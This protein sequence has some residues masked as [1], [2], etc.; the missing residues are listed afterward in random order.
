MNRK[1][2]LLALVIGLALVL[3]CTAAALADD[4]LKVQMDFSKKQFSGPETITVSITVT[5]V[6]EGD[7]PGPVTL[8]YPSGKRVEEFGSP[9]LTVGSSK[10]WQG[11]WT[12]TQ[13]E[14]EDGKITFQIRY[15]IYDEDQDDMV[16]KK[17]NFSKK[18]VFTGA[19]PELT[20]TAHTVTPQLAQKGQEVTVTYEITNS[21]TV[22]VSNVV[23]KENSAISSKSATV[24]EIKA[25][26]SEKVTFVA[27]MGSKDLNSAATVTYKAGGKT[28]TTKSDSQTVKYG[29][30]NL[31]AALEADKKGGAP[32]DPLK[33]KL[34]LKNKGTVDFTNVAVTDAT[35]GTVFSGETVKAGETVTL[36]KDLTITETMDLQFTVTAEDATGIP[37]ETATGLVHVIAMDPTQQ[38]ILSVEAEA[39]RTQ[40]YKIPGNVRFTVRV[41]NESAV[42]VK[43]ITV[44]AVDVAL[45]TFESIPAGETA[46]FTRD[47]AVSMAGSFQFTANCKD[48]L[49]Q[50]LSFAGNIVTI[51]YADPTPVPT[52]APVVTPPAPVTEPVPQD[53]EPL[54]VWME[55]VNEIAETAKWVFAGLAGLL[56]ILLLI[57]AVRRGRSRS[58][59]NKAMDHLEGATYRDYSTAP[60]GGRRSEIVSGAA[61]GPDT[62]DKAAGAENTEQNSDLMAETLRKLYDEKPAEAPEAD[63]DQ[64]VL[65]GADPDTTTELPLPGLEPVADEETTQPEPRVENASDAAHR[66]RVRK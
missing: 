38:I 20:I 54:P 34:T 7:M 37:T 52:E 51:A 63:L 49:G 19:D 1:R 41:H 40:V 23:V 62:F 36:E 29:E 24:D 32:G 45:Y 8:Y 6:G 25:G 3:L 60:R 50:A 12:V 17:K 11:S 13:Q 4:P 59:S 39:D 57:G 56:L 65:P 30:V 58:E 47:M 64:T 35:L 53:T 16:S 66:R 2:L 61:D 18:I 10:N 42:E 31:T 44:K 22:D 43:N 55:T 9:T 28:F 48:Q 21:G 27:T 46:S 14:L 5:N 15:T 26:E 33:L